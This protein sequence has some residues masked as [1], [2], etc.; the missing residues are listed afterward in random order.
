MIS[1]TIHPAQTD[2]VDSGGQQCG[3]ELL[4]HQTAEHHQSRVQRIAVGAAHALDLDRFLTQALLQFIHRL[5]AAVH[6][7]GGLVHVA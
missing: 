5:A 2:G 4:A 1:P 7:D 6:D 3:G